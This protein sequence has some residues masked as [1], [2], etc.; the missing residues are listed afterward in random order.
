MLPS[1]LIEL[2]V[3][4]SV[5]KPKQSIRSK[6]SIL[7]NNKDLAPKANRPL[8]PSNLSPN[9]LFNKTSNG[10]IKMRQEPPLRGVQNVRYSYGLTNARTLDNKENT[11]SGNRKK[12]HTVDGTQATDERENVNP[13][14]NLQSIDGLRRK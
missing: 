2:S 12:G 14:K 10:A 5:T 13:L 3:V 11:G 8:R 4:P 6:A 1:A 9:N 7:V